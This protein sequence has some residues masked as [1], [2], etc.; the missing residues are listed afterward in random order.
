MI[1]P[2]PP[3]SRPR[4]APRRWQLPLAVLAITAGAAA[5]RV[6]DLDRAGLGNQFYAATVYSMGLSPHNFLYAAYDPA[7]TLSV[8]KPPLALWL[9]VLT[10]KALGLEG[11]AMILPM[12]IAGTLAVPLTFGAARRGHGATVGL[13][14]AA[15]L[16]VLPESVA[17]ARDSTMDALVMAL[18]AAAAW[19]LVAAVESRR[20][21][22]L[23]AF[24]AVMGLS[25]NVKFFEGFVLLPAALL[26]IA[27]RWRGEW[28]ARSRS[29]VLAAA[30]GA[31]ICLSWITFYDLTPAE[32]R[33][34]VMNDT[35]N[36]AYGLV[37]R[38]NG[39]ERVLPGEVIVFRPVADTAAA[40]AASA[41]AERHFG[42]GDAGPLRLFR[43][44]N[45]PL[46][47]TTVLLAA[48]GLGVAAWRRRDWLRGPGA[49]WA[50]WFVTGAVLFSFSNRAAAQ[51]T[52][53]YAPALAVMAAVGLVEGWRA[54]GAWRP[55]VLPAALLA[56]TAYAWWTV[57]DHAPLQRGTHLAAA[58]LVAAAAGAL[59]LTPERWLRRERDALRALA[60]AAAV[61]VLL[62]TTWWIAFDAPRAGQITRPN[63][64][65]Y[66]AKDRPDAVTRAIP[67]DL[68]LRA[69]PPDPAR[70]Y[71]LGIDGINNAGEVIA[72][73]RVSV[74]PI[75]NEY[76]RQPLLPEERLEA[77]LRDGEVPVLILSSLRLVTGLLNDVMPVVQRHCQRVNV[78][79]GQAWTVWRCGAAAA[80]R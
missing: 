41:T 62:A 64:V 24:A 34:M 29:L 65:I 45:G 13:A 9:Q 12:A 10:T 78:R 33:P 80:P 36:R 23:V 54:R 60:A 52:E 17:T 61:A 1:A 69:Q 49:F 50:A 48:F 35:W 55:T 38:Y 77:L 32:S 58:V 53:A 3:G 2:E 31:L 75:W 71:A 28:R 51:Y 4:F 46:L 7:A 70:R 39:L 67:A 14:A 74:L 30:A 19:L 44:S 59:A 11:F 57:V 27:L 21:A 43:G 26:Y 37:L 20:A 73:A 15:V 5:L 25:F 22:P 72:T 47:G 76:R 63:P 56:F 6:V 68:V 66:A 18:A 42:V 40:R 16:A 79:V 8:D